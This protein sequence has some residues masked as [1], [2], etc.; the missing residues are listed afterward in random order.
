MAML[1]LSGQDDDFQLLYLALPSPPQPTGVVH[2]TVGLPNH[3]DAVGIT[4]PLYDH[5]DETG[6]RQGC[7]VVDRP[8]G[9]VIHILI[10]ERIRAHAIRFRIETEVMQDAREDVEEDTEEEFP[11]EDPEPVEPRAQPTIQRSDLTIFPQD[12]LRDQVLSKSGDADTVYILG[13]EL[14]GGTTLAAFDLPSHSLLQ[15]MNYPPS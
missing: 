2:I 13:V 4:V 11:S 12:D 6:E 14:P 1:I 3:P 8:N 7:T 10:R 5:D 15:G 9:D